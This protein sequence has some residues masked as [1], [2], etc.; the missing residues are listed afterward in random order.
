MRTYP[1]LQQILL[2]SVA[3]ITLHLSIATAVAAPTNTPTGAKADGSVVQPP[4]IEPAVPQSTFRLPK[5]LAEGRNPFFPQSVRHVGIEATTKT[6]PVV[7]PTAE[8]ALKGISGTAEQPLAIINDRTFSA[9][10]EGDVVTRAGK[11]RIRC[12]EIN[13][14]EGTVLVHV[15]GQSR[16]LRLAP[17][18]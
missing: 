6:N 10:E 9:G 8:L 3:T 12:T 5:K 16:E 18:K 14:S 17:P 15:G 1:C 2:S 11:V 13:M 7:T 4:F